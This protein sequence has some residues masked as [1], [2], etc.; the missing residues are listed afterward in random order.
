MPR[1]IPSGL[2]PELYKL[3][4]K[5]IHL[6]ELYLDSPYTTPSHFYCINNE[7]L[8]FGGQVYTAIAAK[9]SSIKSEEGTI[10]NELNI[11]LDNIDTEFK[12]LISSGAFTRK[13]CDIKLVFDGFLTSASD[14]ILLYSGKLDA[15]SGDNRWINLLIR[16][17]SIFERDYPRRIYEIM[18][19]WTF[20][21]AQCGLNID[22][23]KLWNDVNTGSTS[24]IINTYTYAMTPSY[25][26][27][28]Y[29][30]FLSGNLIGQV[31]PVY[32][33]SASQVI[34]RVAFSE[35]PVFGDSF[36]IQKLCAKTPAACQALSNYTNYGGFPQT[37]KSPII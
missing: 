3:Y 26:V 15:P 36:Y 4:T 11:Q 20:G 31:R 10:I 30:I 22:S 27:P 29:V 25:Y 24:S 32:S 19:N 33:N 8:T 12:N 1:T 9:R 13:R 16:P 34:V 5:P 35:A 7:D 6:A 2:L 37:P 23:Y 17:F 14:Y 18:C 28:G 21:D